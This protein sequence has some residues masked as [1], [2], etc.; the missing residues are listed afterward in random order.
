VALVAEV[1]GSPTARRAWRQ[2]RP[3]GLAL[4][5]RGQ[6]A[7]R[8]GLSSIRP[9]LQ[10]APARPP[11]PPS[12]RITPLTRRS[13]APWRRT[14]PA[15]PP[16]GRRNTVTVWTGWRGGQGGT[17]RAS[18]GS[19]PPPGL[20][21]R[22]SASGTEKGRN[23]ATRAWC[24]DHMAAEPARFAS[25]TISRVSSSSLAARPGR[26]APVPALPRRAQW[27]GV[28]RA[29]P[30][31]SQRRQLREVPG[32]LQPVGAPGGRS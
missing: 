29:P 3:Q 31:S 32:G 4:R 11:R 27:I 30:P 13:S 5:A 22:P 6:S 20:S 14:R 21:R 8:P 16:G 9:V 24:C 26:R 28:L 1:R 18:R 7:E 19:V 23:S 25:A 12:V 10:A 2:D 15:A 17:A